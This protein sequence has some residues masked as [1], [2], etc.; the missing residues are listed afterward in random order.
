MAPVLF[1]KE[2][3]SDKDKKTV[4][5]LHALHIWQALIK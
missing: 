2:R 1:N 3:Q 5:P 4:E